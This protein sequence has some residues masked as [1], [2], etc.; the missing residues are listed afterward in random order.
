[1]SGS[2]VLIGAFVA[3][4]AC[5]PAAAAAAGK[6]T[7]PDTGSDRA[8]AVTVNGL[9][10][11]VE[12]HGSGPP[13]LLL[14]G[15]GSTAQSSFGAIMPVLART[16]HVIAPEQQAHG[17]SGDR[18]G[19][20]SFEQMADDTAALLAK[21][22]VAETDV[23]GFSNGGIVAMQ[24]AIRHPRLV[25]RL[26]LCSSFYGRSAMPPQFW[27]GFAHA[28][29]ADMPPP[30]RAAFIAAAPNQAEVPARFAKQVALMDSFRDIP[31]ASLRGI[32]VKS[33]VMVGDHDVMSV[34]H[35]GQLS[36]LLRHGELAVMP[37]SGHGTYLGAVEGARPGSPLMG[38]GVT[39]IEAFLAG[40]L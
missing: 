17:H 21:L 13:L 35:V 30:L 25:R 24:L 4:L 34:E 1:M 22:G 29:M 32:A 37:G 10:M 31:E 8:G 19:P 12:E 3:L 6:P 39:M 26:I 28:T 36:R 5:M 20:L 7:A 2:R 15:G 38:L 9:R 14:H 40:T 27:Q 18:P 16:H 33:L 23:L 11:Y